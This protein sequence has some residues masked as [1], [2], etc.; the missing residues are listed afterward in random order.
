[1]TG[2]AF[3]EKKNLWCTQLDAWYIKLA[4]FH[5]FFMLPYDYSDMFPELYI[6]CISSIRKTIHSNVNRHYTT[7]SYIYYNSFYISK[8][9]YPPLLLVTSLN[10]FTMFTVCTLDTLLKNVQ[11][12]SN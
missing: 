9:I 8:Y 7:S 10:H 5:P 4:T 2:Q 3:V 6:T 12:K 1:M 11:S